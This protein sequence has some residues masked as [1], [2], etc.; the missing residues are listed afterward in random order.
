MKN[1]P[2]DIGGSMPMDV[3]VA[4]PAAHT[5]AADFVSL[6]KPRLNFLVLITTMVGFYIGAEEPTVLLVL[7]TLVGTALVAGGASALNQVWEHD[8]DRLMR[9]TRMRPL[10]DRRLRVAEGLRFGLL[11][12]AVGLVELALT[13]NMRAAVI[14]AA[15]LVSYTLMYT[16]LKRRSS[17]ATIVGA[18][19][20]ALP[21]VIGWAAATNTLS[22][23]AWILFAIVFVWQMPH[24]LAIG[25]MFRDEYANAGIPLLPVIEPDGRSTG[26]QSVIYAAALVPVSL[27]PV[28]TGMAGTLYLVGALL[29]GGLLLTSAARF[30]EQRTMPAAR[31]MFFGSI[32]YLPVLWAFLLLDHAR[33]F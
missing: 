2:A 4:A 10:P 23:E 18:V 7:H 15:T 28:L 32:L 12:S 19:P 33:V 21:P 30:A 13:V 22:V 26:R 16:P 9:R 11:L 31:T 3:P 24:F 20:G 8:S 27:A 6:T 5:R 25:W 17:L 1:P 29:L 14:A